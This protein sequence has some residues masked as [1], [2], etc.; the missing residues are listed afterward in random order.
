MLLQESSQLTIKTKHN[1]FVA[2]MD[3]YERVRGRPGRGEGRAP[4][5]GHAPTGVNLIYCHWTKTDTP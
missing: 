5:L 1:L 4:T 2:A 3:V